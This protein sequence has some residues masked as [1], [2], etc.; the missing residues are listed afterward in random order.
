MVV[1]VKKP[2]SLKSRLLL[3]VVSIDQVRHRVLGVDGEPKPLQK[4]PTTTIKNNAQAL[5]SY[6]SGH[7]KSMV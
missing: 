2:L 6:V 1:D 4:I 7:E 5:G 3:A